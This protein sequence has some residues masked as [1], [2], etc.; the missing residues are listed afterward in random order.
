MIDDPQIHTDTPLRTKR[1]LDNGMDA[2]DW[3]EPGVPWLARSVVCVVLLLV[4]A[5]WAAVVLRSFP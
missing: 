3:Y 2:S 1:T 5:L 4:L